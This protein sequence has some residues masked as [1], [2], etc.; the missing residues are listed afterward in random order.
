MKTLIKLKQKAGTNI[1]NRLNDLKTYNNI[2]YIYP[3]F[4]K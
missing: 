1:I 2:D 4:L 3:S